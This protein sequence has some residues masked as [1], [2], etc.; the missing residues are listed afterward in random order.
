MMNKKVGI[1]DRQTENTTLQDALAALQEIVDLKAKVLPFPKTTPRLHA[2][3]L[4][5]VSFNAHKQL[6]VAEIKTIAITGSSEEQ[7][8]WHCFDCGRETSCRGDAPGRQPR[9]FMVRT[10]R[11]GLVAT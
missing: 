10:T 6:F 9:S 8:N 7:V 4:V 1:W 3:A 11:F 5:E 2:D